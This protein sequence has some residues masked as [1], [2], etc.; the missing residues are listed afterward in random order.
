MNKIKVI[1][2]SSE[3]FAFLNFERNKSE[4][5]DGKCPHC[6]KSYSK[7]AKL[8]SH[9][10][11][12]HTEKTGLCFKCGKK[13]DGSFG[14]GAYCSRSCA[15]SRTFSE[16]S[17]IKK[18]KLAKIVFM[19]NKNIKTHKELESE[20]IKNLNSIHNDKYTYPNIN[21]RDSKSSINIF[22]KIHGTFSQLYDNHKKGKG[23]FKCAEEN[24][25]TNREN[26]IKEVSII[27]NNKYD[28]SKVYFKKSLKEEII[29][30]CPKHKEFTQAGHSHKQ[31]YGCKKCYLESISKKI[32]KTNNT[33]IDSFKKVHGDKYDYSF[34]KYRRAIEDIDIFCKRCKKLFTQRPNNH[35]QGQGCPTC[36]ETGF[37]LSKPAI[38]YYIKIEK[39]GNIVYKIGVTNNDV[40]KRFKEE[41]KYITVVRSY[42]YE[43]GQEAYDLEQSI[44]RDYSYAKYTGDP[45]LRSGNTEMFIDDVLMWDLSF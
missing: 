13:H 37:D 27:H 42:W 38:L 28:Y 25:L 1:I 2:H 22:C 6:A 14:I 31:G 16:E 7:L 36:A 23:C 35:Q 11:K 34:V 20:I 3:K 40:K 29:I 30:I 32:F 24:R 12:E 41:Y 17:K 9:I 4:I 39:D 44:L 21:Y 10:F 43:N 18:S 45:I 19:K 5:I 15:N 26:F 33:I 8:K